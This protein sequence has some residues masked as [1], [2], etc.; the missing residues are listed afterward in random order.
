MSTLSTSATTAPPAAA[1]TTTNAAYGEWD[2]PISGAVVASGSRSLASPWMVGE[3]IYWLE[4]R[5]AEGGRMTLLR[6]HQQQIEEL[7]PAPLNV[8][9]RVHEYGGGAVAAD[10]SG[11]VFSNFSD[12][13]LYR[14][15]DGNAPVCISD[16][17]KA[18]RYDDFQFDPARQRVLCV[19]EDHRQSSLRPDNFLCAVAL[20]G[21][22]QRQVLHQGYDFYAAPRL[23]PDGQQLAWLCWNHPN[24]PWQGT[25]LWLADMAADGSLQNARCIAG[26]STEA[27]CQPCWA[28]SGQLYF[29]SD[30]SDWWNIYR[31]L[32]LAAHGHHAECIYQRAA[33]F[34]GPMWSFDQP[35]LGFAS[36]NDLLCI[37][38]EQATC[39]LAHIDTGNCKLREIAC[40]YPDLQALRV[41]GSQVLLLAG[42]PDRAS[43]LIS[44]N[45]HTGA[46]NVLASSIDQLPAADYLS[47]PQTISY[48]GNGRTAHAFYYAPHNTRYQAPAGSLPPLIVIGHG[49]PTGMANQSFKM[50]IQYWT[51][52][53]FAMLDVNYGGSS[54]FG[55]AY[56]DSL[57]GEWGVVDVEDCANGARHLV[58]QGLVDADRLII[59]GGSAGGFT[60]LMALMF[61]DVFKT[62]ACYYG[63]S[64]LNSLDQDSHKFE[65]HYNQYLIAPPPHNQALYQQRS[66][67]HHTDKLR[68]PVIFFQG[69]DDKV[70][71]PS[72]SETMVSAMRQRGVPV[73]YLP[74]AGEGHG[75]RQAANIARTLEAELY[76]YCKVLHLALP[77]GVAPVEIDN[78]A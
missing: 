7:T 69:L 68:C 22:A 31:Y 47:R 74:L 17:D 44:I 46:L 9:S 41:S 78:L 21:S 65:S 50:A 63:V 35:M 72:Q 26:S 14:I 54:G 70:V 12:N 20:D 27:I 15:T 37:Y 30:R 55:R 29:V 13:Q 28:P 6:Q 76:F 48:P 71:P 40:P 11:V 33:E 45:W 60:T 39:H 19:A 43:A 49:G 4:S 57:K 42:A 34:G 75:F 52:R 53:G 32:P 56:R 16:G 10:A 18:L 64:D 1:P 23:S 5:A 59:R 38:I 73:A 62:G 8:R 66:P 61:H 67:C 58:A 77:A 51:S 3:T 24:M 25:E 2:S 36:A